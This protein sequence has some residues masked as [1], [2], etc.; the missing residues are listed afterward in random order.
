MVNLDDLPN[1]EP[2]KD[3]ADKAAGATRPTS[4]VAAPP[5]ATAAA[6]AT[7]KTAKPVSTQFVPTYKDPGF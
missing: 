3:K 1:V 2:E 7:T 4:V 5:T 6:T